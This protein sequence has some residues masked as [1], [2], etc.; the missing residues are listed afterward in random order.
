M[1]KIAKKGYLDSFVKPTSEWWWGLCE[2]IVSIM[3]E[4]RPY[5]SIEIYDVIQASSLS[6][7]VKALTPNDIKYITQ[8][9]VGGYFSEVNIINGSQWEITISKPQKPNPDFNV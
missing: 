2:W 4:N 8:W 5:L 1:T 6:A 7:D 9:M 3:T